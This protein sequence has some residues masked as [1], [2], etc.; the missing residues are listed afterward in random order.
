L[1][2]DRR[3]HAA[4]YIR[5]GEWED[6][7]K[8]T[9]RPQAPASCGIIRAVAAR[10]AIGS[11]ELRAVAAGVLVVANFSS[12]SL[13][14]AERPLRVAQDASPGLGVPHRPFENCLATDVIGRPPQFRFDG[15]TRYHA[16]ARVAKTRRPSRGFIR[17]RPPSLLALMRR[18]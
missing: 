14:A 8:L 13:R 7:L 17:P 15:D 9:I 3:V 6:A 5:G 18:R 12:R 2:V 4:D 16:L 10:K 11:R 1:K